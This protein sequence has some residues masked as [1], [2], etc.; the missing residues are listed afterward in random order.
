MSFKFDRGIF[1]RTKSPFIYISRDQS[2]HKEFELHM[3]N[4]KGKFEAG[5][6][7]NLFDEL[8]IKLELMIQEP[9]REMSIVR[10]HLETACF[11][12]K[13]A[14]AIRLENQA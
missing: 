14:M 3:L 6:I 9:G 8:L 7:A 5:Q 1:R 13:K 12:A 2:M 10:T 4:D 11:F